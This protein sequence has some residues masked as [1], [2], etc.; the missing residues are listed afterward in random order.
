M[1]WLSL[2]NYVSGLAKE[3]GWLSRWKAV[4][5]RDER[6]KDAYPCWMYERCMDKPE[7]PSVPA[8][9]ERQKH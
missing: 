5:A 2:R 4:G 6:P 3:E 8:D 7:E 1:S 9:W